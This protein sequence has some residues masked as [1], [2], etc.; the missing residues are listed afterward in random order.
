[1]KRIA[2]A[3]VATVLAV[4]MAACSGPAP[5][6][7]SGDDE[8]K[9]LGIVAYI[10]NNAINQQT[11]RGATT[12]AEENGW[13]VTVTDTQGDADLANATMSTTPHRASA[14]FVLVFAL[15]AL[16]GGLAAEAAGFR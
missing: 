4:A 12:V 10:G 11:I 5:S 16:G 14:E 9:T 1:M 13:E 2:V 3:A 15:T 6:T 7:G 8:T